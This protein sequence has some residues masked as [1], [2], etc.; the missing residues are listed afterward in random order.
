MQADFWLHPSSW[1][2]KA[3]ILQN[4]PR[5]NVFPLWLNDNIYQNS[6]RTGKNGSSDFYESAAVYPDLVLSDLILI[7]HP[8][9]LPRHNFVYYEPLK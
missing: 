6:K 1:K 4:E 5:M 2:N 7:F 3:E 8:E 9:I